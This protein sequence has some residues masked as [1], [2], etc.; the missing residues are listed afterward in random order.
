[1]YYNMTFLFKKKKV[2]SP[3]N[4]FHFEKRKN[5]WQFSASLKCTI[6][7]TLIWFTSLI[8][9]VKIEDVTPCLIYVL[10]MAL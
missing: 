9:C 4:M 8:F 6:C 2:S 1:M 7:G 5:T 3:Q 10:R